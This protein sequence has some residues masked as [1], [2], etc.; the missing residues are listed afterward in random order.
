MKMAALH[1]CDVSGGRSVYLKP[2]LR[3]YVDDEVLNHEETRIVR[4]K[5]CV[6]LTI[7]KDGWS[8]LFSGFKRRCTFLH[9]FCTLKIWKIDA[10]KCKQYR[11]CSREETI[12]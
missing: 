7:V 12:K 11:E 6:K 8:L 2:C 4:G 3:T 10:D 1:D 5:K 9:I